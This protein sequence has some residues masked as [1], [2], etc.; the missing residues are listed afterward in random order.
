MQVLIHSLPFTLT[1]ELSD[2]AKDKVSI[3]AEKFKNE[4]LLLI[5]EK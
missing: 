3:V 1:P 2:F 5:K 4:G